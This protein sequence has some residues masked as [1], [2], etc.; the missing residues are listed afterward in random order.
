MAEEEKTKEGAVQPA[1]EPAGAQPAVEA[2]PEAQHNKLLLAWKAP[3]F[4][5]HPKGKRWFLT[6]G[7]ITLVLIAYALY[8]NSATMAIVFIV[9][10]GVLILLSSH[11]AAAGSL[12]EYYTSASTE[13]LKTETREMGIEA[14]C[15][16]G[17]NKQV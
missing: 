10:A 6:A 1:V 12:Y 2:A 15:R 14:I 16:N 17:W 5:S 4:I 11:W 3:E 7:I 13:T 8:T 9:L